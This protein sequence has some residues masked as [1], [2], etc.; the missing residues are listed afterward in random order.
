MCSFEMSSHIIMAVESASEARLS[1]PQGN[2]KPLSLSSSI[3]QSVSPRP[4]GSQGGWQ[5]SF[6]EIC[7]YLYPRL[8]ENFLQIR[9]PFALSV[10]PGFQDFCFTKVFRLNVESF[11]LFAPNH[12]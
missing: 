4:K 6:T 5:C 7:S 1:E 2:I 12:L 3:P 11:T 8:T 9:K 10:N